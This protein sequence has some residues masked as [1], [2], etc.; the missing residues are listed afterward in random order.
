MKFFLIAVLAGFCALSAAEKG[1]PNII[2]WQGDNTEQTVQETGSLEVFQKEGKPAADN[3]L[4]ANETS[5]EERLTEPTKRYLWDPTRDRK[6]GAGG[7][8]IPGAAF[9][10]DTTALFML[11]TV[12]A[13]DGPFDTRLVILATRTG[14]IIRV[15][16]F[17]KVRYVKIQTLPDSDDLLLAEAPAEN[18][19]RIVR[20]NPLNGKIRCAADLP[21]FSDWLIMGS[22]L[23]SKDQDS[24]FLRTL[25]SQNLAQIQEIKTAAPGGKLLPEKENL[26]NNMH[27]GSPA[28][29]ERIPLPGAPQLYYDEKFLALP[30]N[31]TP[32]SGL[33]FGETSPM[34][35]WM[36]PGGAA[37][38]RIGKNFHSLADRVNGLAAY[39]PESQTLFLGLQKRDMIA[40]FRPAES[41]S[42][43]R[44]SPTGQ[45]KPQTRGDSKLITCVNA[46]NVRILI[47]DHRAN[48]YQ[49][50]LPHKSRNW[51]KTLLFIPGK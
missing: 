11:E 50:Q 12:G 7:A 1:T 27:P 24:P 13:D 32:A 3:S 14:E 42:Q 41:T 25:S 30:D 33:Y 26:V 46:S 31:F 15:Q 10:A 28:K 9:S 36:E 45:L 19:Q 4:E 29:L 37:M 47:L 18:K 48:F 44:S 49:I 39:H 17:A 35:L 20:L 23:L 34:Q 16:R 6:R 40:E 5:S 22:F 43:L 51:K 21:V 8:K 38:L 2:R